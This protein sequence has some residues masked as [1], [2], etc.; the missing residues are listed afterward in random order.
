MKRVHLRMTIEVEMETDRKTDTESL[1]KWAE[2]IE[3]NFGWDVA[4]YFA[5]PLK[6][7]KVS[8]DSLGEAPHRDR[9]P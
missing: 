5:T 3:N 4:E 8:V 9:L 1:L 2:N 6:K 7:V